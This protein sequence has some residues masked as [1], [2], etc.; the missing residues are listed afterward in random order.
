LQVCRQQSGCK[1]NAE[2][3]CRPPQ[4]VHVAILAERREIAILSCGRKT[5]SGTLIL[6]PH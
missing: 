3:C 5:R 4:P 6:L 2:L 1:N